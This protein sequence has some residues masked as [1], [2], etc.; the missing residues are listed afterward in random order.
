M[1]SYNIIVS[2]IQIY[3]KLLEKQKLQSSEV[4]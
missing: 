3:M 2:F 1:F 4:V